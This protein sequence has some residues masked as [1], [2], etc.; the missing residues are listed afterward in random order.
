MVNKYNADGVVMSMYVPLFVCLYGCLS[1]CLSVVW[2]VDTGGLKEPYVRRGP[3]LQ[4]IWVIWGLPCDA[5]FRQIF[6]T[7]FYHLLSALVTGE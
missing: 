2:V 5:A 4:W 3:G 7:T 6:L 1:V